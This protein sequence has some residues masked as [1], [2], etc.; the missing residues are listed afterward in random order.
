MAIGLWG[1]PAVMEFID[2]R[3]QLS[4]DQ[5]KEVLNKYIRMQ[6][7]HGI[8]YWPVFL[9]ATGE[10]VGCCGLRPYDIA[11]PVYEFGVQI[12]REWWRQG[13]AEEAAR[14]VIAYAFNT[15]HA[16]ALFAGHNPNNGASQSLIRKLGFRY[17][18]SEFYPGTG[19]EHPSYLL[20]AP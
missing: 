11:K 14:A 5:V 10:H 20:T 1:D 8:Q 7:E 6:R 2:S 4:H 12:R 19:L 17:T 15:L 13:F 18:H 9:M 3:R 16:G